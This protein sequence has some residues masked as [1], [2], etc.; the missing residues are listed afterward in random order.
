MKS[1]NGIPAHAIARFK[2]MFLDESSVHHIRQ[3]EMSQKDYGEEYNVSAELVGKVQTGKRYGWIRN[4][5]GTKYEPVVNRSLH[6]AISRK[7]KKK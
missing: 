7:R 5:D 3:R 4:P 1:F 2:I 6:C